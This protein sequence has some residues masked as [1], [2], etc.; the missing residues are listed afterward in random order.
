MKDRSEWL[1]LALIVVACGSDDPVIEQTSQPCKL[2]K[3]CYPT[4]DAAALRGE[5]VC[6]DRVPDGYCTHLCEQDSDC[7]AVPGECKTGHPQVCAPFEST[8]QKQCFLSCESEIV[9]EAKST[10]ANA[11]CALYANA[12]FGCRSTGGGSENRKVCMP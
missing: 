5:P 1:L 3:E 7:C 6:L 2:A 9:T 8:G 4:L 12:A 11:Y 10:D